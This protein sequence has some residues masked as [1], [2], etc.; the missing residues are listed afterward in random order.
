MDRRDV[1]I[2]SVEGPNQRRSLS[3]SR[4]SLLP[5]AATALSATVLALS[6]NVA[7]SLV[8]HEWTHRHQTVVWTTVAVLVLVSMLV[9]VLRRDQGDHPDPRIDDRQ[10]DAR[11]TPTTET[12]V[13]AATIQSTVVAEPG[14]YVAIGSMGST[15][16]S[17]GGVGNG[18]NASLPDD[19]YLPGRPPFINRKRE[20]KELISRVHAGRENV[21]TIDGN[22]GIGK[23]AATTELVHC[24]RSREP[25]GAFDPREHRF[26]WFDAHDGC[27][28]LTELCGRLSLET[29]DQLLSAT[30]AAFKRD[31]LRVYLARSKTVLV[32]DNLRLSDDAQ[33]QEMIDLLEHLPNGSLVIASINR[34]GALVAPRVPLRD[35][36]AANVHR[37][38]EDWAR[39]LNLDGIE[40]FDEA[41][42]TRL[43]GL[44]GGNPGVVEWFLR[45]Y[46]GSSQSLEERVAA[47]E[48]GGELSD[49]FDPTWQ[50]LSDD[51]KCALEACA[52][53]GGEATA[54]QI[55]IA[56][57]RPE[58]EMRSATDELRDEGMLTPVRAKNR[59][60]IYTCDRAFQLFVTS[61][62]AGHIRAAFTERLADHYI[63]YFTANP[64]DAH[65]G[66]S[67][68]GAWSVV[69]GEL[70]EDS[71]DTRIQALFRA[72]MDILFTLGQYD[73]LIAA[74]ELSFESAR[75]IDNHPDAT[76]AAAIKAGTHTI[77]GEMTLASDA[78]AHASIAA[79]S[80]GLPGP[81]A[82]VARLRGFLLYR[83]RKAREALV[84]IEGTEEMAR[85]AGERIN[86][87]DTLD[88]RTAANWYLHRFDACEAAANE[89]LKTGAAMHWH[90]ARAYPLRYLAE[91]AIQRRQTQQARELL[92]EA[93][94][95]A[96]R[97]GDKRQRARVD[98]TQARLCLLEGDL[99]LG[100]SAAA[101]AVSEATRLGLPPEREEAAALAVAIE[102][103]QRSWLWRRYYA[104]R[105]PTRLT[106][107]PVGGD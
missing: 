94:D 104:L 60:T 71:D 93:R 5:A 95:I 27:P 28:S 17:T 3:R 100:A 1:R 70:F 15:Q 66:A 68:V 105:R 78:L 99:D 65:Y 97:F 75:R 81:T 30:S 51:C 82:W 16:Q 31:E 88:L 52:Y 92:D 107:A 87:V 103:A 23:S 41:F 34:P 80:S 14:S 33:S 76:L 56:C 84:A 12:W 53:L 67:E 10:M 35:F 61:K 43:H 74:A 48:Q 85:A 106:D 29:D 37:L 98:L 47:I 45:G 83:S 46:R 4:R 9:A 8:P 36:N 57:D 54:Q 101:R 2:R 32:L 86:H 96:T 79:E 24:L 63:D 102:R 11:R 18:P 55:S 90:R 44:I 26:V 40:Q 22:Q 25:E 73:E 39:R 89:S 49:L 21:L 13:Q 77:R 62:A 59:P 64:E 42:A 58:E 19:P 6:I 38:I 72:V 7:A 20:M 91:L 50:A 69:R